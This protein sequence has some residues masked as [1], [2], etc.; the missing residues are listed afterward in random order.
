MLDKA[1]PNYAAGILSHQAPVHIGGVR[2]LARDA[3]ALASYYEGVIG[4]ERIA[5]SGEAIELGAGG[6][7]F[8]TILAAPKAMAENPRGAGLFHTAF[9]LPSRAA[10]GAWFRAAEKRGARLDGASD[11][12]VSEAFYLTDPEGN[13]IE[14]Y[15][16][17]P[18][19]TWQ[20]EGDGFALTTMRMDLAGVLEAGQSLAAPDKVPAETRIGHVHL[21]VGDLPKAEAFYH[22]TIGL[23]VISRRPGG[24]F[25]S[26]GRYHHHIATNIWASAGAAPR[27]GHVTGL[28]RMHLHVADAARFAALAEALVAEGAQATKTSITMADPWS[29]AI[30]FDLLGA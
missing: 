11:H 24:I 21:R 29:I 12:A 7:V 26:W 28:E 9:L 23:E 8:L 6:Q 10:L 1:M 18:R 25:Y 22:G 27:Q 15:A 3:A 16:D 14:V 19:E 13:G 20:R 17:R 30:Q 2:L 4:L 5:A